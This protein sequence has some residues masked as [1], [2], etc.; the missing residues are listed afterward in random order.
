MAVRIVAQGADAG[1]GLA[2]Q[3]R[4]GGPLPFP[5][6]HHAAGSRASDETRRRSA[7]WRG[8][9]QSGPGE[10]ERSSS[11]GAASGPAAG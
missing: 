7:G 11:A 4:I 5:A 3:D 10:I 8:D 9:R 1:N 2:R 6:A